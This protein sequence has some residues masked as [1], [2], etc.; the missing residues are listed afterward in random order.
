MRSSSSGSRRRALGLS[1]S[2]LATVCTLATLTLVLP[3]FTESAP[4]PEFTSS[5][6][7]FAAIASIAVYALFVFVQAI[8]H[9]DYFL[10]VE[11]DA[12]HESHGE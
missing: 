2:A 1:P 5:Q 3:T 4:G 7:T 10:P 11:E 9:R 12:G 6:L 8:R